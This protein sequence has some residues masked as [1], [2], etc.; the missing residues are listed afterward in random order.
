MPVHLGRVPGFENAGGKVGGKRLNLE[1]MPCGQIWS[2]GEDL[3]QVTFPFRGH[4]Q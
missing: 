3:C 2:M 4:T 1:R